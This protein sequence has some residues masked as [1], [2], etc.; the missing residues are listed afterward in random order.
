MTPKAHP[1]THLGLL[2]FAGPDAAQFLQGQLSNDVNRLAAGEALLAS[3]SSPQG[4]VL[5]VLW[6]LKLGEEI[7][8]ILPRELLAATAERLRKYVLRAKLKVTDAGDRLQ[9]AGAFTA[10]GVAPPPALATARMQQDPTRQ[11]LILDRQASSTATADNDAFAAAWRL[12][13]I[14]AG[15]PQVYA[16][17]S[18]EFVAQMLNLDELDGISFNKGC[19][20]GQEIIARTHYLGRVKRRLHKLEL[21]RGE[22]QP[23]QAITLDDGRQGVVVE[24]AVSADHC[25][26][27]VVS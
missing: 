4:R 7:L 10:S 1:L 9:V 6:L 11:W 3:Y 23:G 15:L 26:L 12:A 8:A 18:G 27:L 25:E 20:T 5:A 13:D 21:P 14:R 22:F 16:A 19:Y 17:T 24:S 2:S